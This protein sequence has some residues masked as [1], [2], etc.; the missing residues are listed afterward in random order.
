MTLKVRVDRLQAVWQ[1][2]PVAV[3]QA[4]WQLQWWL[5]TPGPIAA[6]G[7][8]EPDGAALVARLEAEYGVDDAG[9]DA[10]FGQAL[11]RLG[12]PARDVPAIVD[13][14][15][16]RFFDVVREGGSHRKVD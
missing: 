6:P 15:L 5:T 10:A 16:A 8:P 4:G 7:Q 9:L 11:R 13:F 12:V 14:G 1:A 3:S 2:N